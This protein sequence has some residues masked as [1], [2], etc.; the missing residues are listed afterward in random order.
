FTTAFGPG[1]ASTFLAR[2]LTSR[3]ELLPNYYAVA[4]G[5]L[6]NEIAV[7][8]GQG[9]TVQTAEDCPQYDDVS[10]TTLGDQGQALGSGCVYPST[11]KT[12]ADELTAGGSTWKAYVEDAGN[13]GS[14]VPATCRH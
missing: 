13:G 9:P 7:I 11:S 2:T 8:S 5:E 10:P 3:G 1:S 14:G 6:A 4:S 12:L